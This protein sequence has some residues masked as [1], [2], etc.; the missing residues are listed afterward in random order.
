MGVQWPDD[1]EHRRVAAGHYLAEGYEIKRN[2]S[3]AGKPPLWTVQHVVTGRWIPNPDL[4]FDTLT[5]AIEA[6]DDDVARNEK[7]YSASTDIPSGTRVTETQYLYQ[8][9]EEWLWG[10]VETPKDGDEVLPDD[11]MVFVQWDER[12]RQWEYVEDLTLERTKE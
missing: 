9:R 1:W 4:G 5:E 12:G 3:H 7:R 2:P 11:G 8:P 6:T 10:T